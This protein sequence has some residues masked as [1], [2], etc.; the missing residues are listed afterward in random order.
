M[1]TKVTKKKYENGI[2]TA[3]RKFRIHLFF[4]NRTRISVW[5]PEIH[6]KCKH[7]VFY[8]QKHRMNFMVVSK[9][10]SHFRTAKGKCKPN[11]F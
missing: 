7:D 5:K 3:T 4:L 2:Y 8:F 9:G 1:T 6:V 11:A 10:L